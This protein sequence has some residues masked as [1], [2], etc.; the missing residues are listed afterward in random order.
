M[1][2]QHTPG[3]W[4]TTGSGVRDRGGY[5]CHTNPA[6]RYEGQD[7]RFAKE[8]A[9]RAANK[10]LIA[11][12]PHLLEAT[13][14]YLQAQDALDNRELQGPNAEDYCVLLR[15]RNAARDDLDAAISKAISGFSLTAQQL[16]DSHRTGDAALGSVA[17]AVGST[18]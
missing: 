1:S 8:T 3:P 4:W 17:K 7:D 12:A 6:Q 9:E 2:G 10:L 15:R 16:I 18:S 11:A 14:A 5:I 13:E